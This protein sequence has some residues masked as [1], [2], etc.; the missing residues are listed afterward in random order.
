[1]KKILM[2]TGG[3][4][5]H[6]Y[7]ALV[8]AQELKGRGWD[9]LF[10]G[11]FGAAG[12]KIKDA[13]FT[14]VDI[15]A[16]GIVSKGP[17]QA[18]IALGYLIKNFFV[19]AA[20]VMRYRP[21]VVLGFGGYSSFSSVAAGAVLGKRTMIHEQNAIPGFANKVLSKF[22]RR[23]A[24]TFKDAQ[25]CFPKG[26]TVWTG[27]PLRPLSCS[28]RR[29][30][31][32]ESFGF[33]EGQ[34]TILVF[35]GSQGAKAINEAFL[36]ALSGLSKGASWQVIHLTG[37][38]SFDGVKARYSMLPVTAFIRAYSDNMAEAYSVADVV[39]GRSGA[40]TVTE[41]G[42][43]GIPAVLIPYPYAKNHQIANARVLE[44]YKTGVIIEEKD[45][46][47]DILRDK[48]F[49][50]LQGKSSRE[51]NREKL[52]DDFASDAVIRLADEVDRLE[53]G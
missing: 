1:M 6:I 36:N 18:L 15:Q 49:L 12:E 40:G 24:V 39:I 8:T 14:F 52:K 33:K 28:R 3:T 32:L 30:E 45:L 41:V 50:L 5:G 46:N 47:G 2:A 13:G 25:R 23:I 35:G 26:K 51:E 31:I 4:G 43:L 34:K 17:L 9:V 11:K 53:N 16:R 10:M 27:C 29:G 21:Q 48:I 38:S 20:I 44:R 42:L 7:P 19:G 22:V 37:H